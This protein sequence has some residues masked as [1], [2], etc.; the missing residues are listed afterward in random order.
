MSILTYLSCG[1]GPA[2]VFN[3]LGNIATL[4][5]IL[6]WATICYT[7]I[8]FHAAM[9]A[10]GINRDDLAYKS[11]F[12]P[13]LSWICLVFFIVVILINGFYA[14][15]PWDTNTFITSYIGIP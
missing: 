8:R 5:A 6:A 14:F 10:Q 1:D 3:W 11:P 2:Q 9:K 15:T 4:S 12:Q 13:Y 7:Y